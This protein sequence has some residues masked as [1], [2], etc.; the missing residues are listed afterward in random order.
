MPDYPKVPQQISDPISENLTKLRDLFPAAVKDGALDVEALR[1]ELGEFE[2][3]NPGDETYELNWV[4]KRAAKKEAF[5]PLLGKTLALKDDGKNSDTTKNLYIEG[6]NLEVLKLL[7]QNYYG[8]VKMIYID[9]PYNTGEDFIYCDNFTLTKEESDIEEGQVSETGNRLIKNE[10]TS[11]RFHARWLDMMYPRLRLAKDLLRED[12]VIFISIDDNEVANLKSACSEIF[13]PDNF[14]TTFCWEKKKKPSFLNRNI[15][16]K[17]EYIMCFAKNRGCTEAFSVD[18]T[19]AGKKYP[20]NN[21]GN[22]ISEITFPPKSVKFKIND[23]AIEPQ[24]MSGGNIITSL[25]NRLLIKDGTN[26]NQFTLK[27]EWRYSQSKIDQIIDDE[28]E[29]VISKIPFRPNH[30]KKGGE[31]KKMH[32]LLTIKHYE[33]ATNEDATKEQEELLGKSFFDY[34]KPTDLINL[35]ARAF[36]YDSPDATILDF[37]SGTATT[38]HAIM[39]LN[40]QDG[41]ARTFIMVQLPELCDEKSD[42]SKFGYKTIAEIGKER[43]RRAGE[44]IKEELKAKHAEWKKRQAAEAKKGGKLALNEDE[45]VEE[46]NAYVLDPDSLDIGFKSFRIQDTKINWLKK[47]LRGVDIIAEAGLTTQDA[48]DFVPGYTDTD[49]IYELM[50]R[51]SNIPLT[52]TIAKP[53]ASAKRTYLYADAYLVCLEEKI[54]QKLVESLAA[55]EPTPNK[56][57]FRDSAFGT[58]IALKDET[59]R[60]LKAEIHKQHGDLGAAYTVEFI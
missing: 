29:I 43:I 21:A 31:V 15:G 1:A 53:I 42:A 60:R 7:R 39:K 23:S 58:D 33:I 48:L 52:G 9:P 38:A 54:T 25:E 26:E 40:A 2:E 19:E 49:V 10:K 50:L 28:E 20:L 30:I 56:Y 44:K 51:Q 4:G 18:F 34:S 32:N 3:V 17:F 22:G 16:T 47:D 37:Y 35:L 8:E 11:N 36:L 14:I 6:D 45:A 41:G 57:F 55:I 13:G 24:D 27:G 46:P 59:F 5:K 12:G